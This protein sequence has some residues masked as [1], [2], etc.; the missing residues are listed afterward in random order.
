LRPPKGKLRDS[1]V[2]AW[3]GFAY[4]LCSERNPRIYMAATA[5]VVALGFWLHLNA[6]E[7]ALVIVAIAFVFTAEMLNTVVE[8][9]VD[10]ITLEQHPL[11]KKAKD[12]AAG[13]VLVAS[14][15]AAAVGIVV[16]GPPLW[17]KLVSLWG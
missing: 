1:F 17:L 14:M 15:A 2:H 3:A 9:V 16:L 13:S 8:C 10:L 7:W 6:R 12:V 5:L 11:A 4:V